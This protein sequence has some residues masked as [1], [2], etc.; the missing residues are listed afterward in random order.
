MVIPTPTAEPCIAAIVGLRQ[1]WIAS[2]T[3]PPL[4][5]SALNGASSKETGI[6]LP[7][8]VISWTFPVATEANIQVR[9]RTED[10]ACARQD[11]NLDPF[12]DVKHGEELFE[13]IDHLPSEGI[14]VGWS[15]QSHNDDW[16]Y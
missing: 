4:V 12:V 15:V 8:A 11:N 2:A 9:T 5:S 7:I 13:I 6:Y 16:G 1:R 10:L 3:R 14:A